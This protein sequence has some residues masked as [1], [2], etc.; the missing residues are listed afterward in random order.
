MQGLFLLK[1][2]ILVYV[3]MLALQALA[4]ASRCTLTLLG[5]E[6]PA[7]PVEAKRAVSTP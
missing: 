2:V 5:R 4:M 6:P 1:S 7:G 3:L